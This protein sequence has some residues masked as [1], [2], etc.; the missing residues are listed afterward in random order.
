MAGTTLAIFGHLLNVYQVASLTTKYPSVPLLIDLLSIG[1]LAA[2]LG[3]LLYPISRG[4]GRIWAFPW[5]S[6][7]QFQLLLFQTIDPLGSS[8]YPALDPLE[9]VRRSLSRFFGMSLLLL[10][11]LIA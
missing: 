5:L 4:H 11:S 7:E 10:G 8:A 6:G 3:F 9:M 1:L 2:M